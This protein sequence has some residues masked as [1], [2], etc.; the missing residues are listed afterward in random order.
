MFAL[1]HSLCEQLYSRDSALGIVT[2]PAGCMIRDSNPGRGKSFLLYKPSRPAVGPKQ[3]SIHS[4]LVCFPEDKAVGASGVSLTYI[5]EKAKNEWSYTST[6]TPHK[7]SSFTF[8]FNEQLCSNSKAATFRRCQV[9]ISPPDILSEV[10]RGV[11]HSSQINVGTVPRNV[12]QLLPF[13]SF[14][15]YSL[16]SSNHSSLS[17]FGS[18]SISKPRISY[19]YDSTQLV[20]SILSA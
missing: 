11:F 10:D 19:F 12:L 20:V 9:R 8:F 17:S 14:S 15:I 2:R 13:T 3:P 4:I 1:F 16:L 6:S 5:T 7:I 18:A